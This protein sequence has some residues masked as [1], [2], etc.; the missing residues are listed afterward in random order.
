MAKQIKSQALARLKVLALR[1][2]SPVDDGVAQALEQ[3]KKLAASLEKALA[4]FKKDWCEQEPLVSEAETFARKHEG[5]KKEDI[6]NQTTATVGCF[7]KYLDVPEGTIDNVSLDNNKD[8]EAS[9]GNK[10]ISE[11][12]AKEIEGND[13]E[14]D[15]DA[16]DGDGDDDSVEDS[17]DED[18]ED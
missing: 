9:D 6:A 10:A 13:D 11:D 17:D 8:P 16:D 1:S 5:A 14:D 12:E 4:D 18:S 7:L 15:A 2:A 3:N